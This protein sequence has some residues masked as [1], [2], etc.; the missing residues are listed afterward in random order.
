[1]AL[2]HIREGAELLAHRIDGA[3]KLYLNGLQRYHDP[4]WC[5][6]PL[7]LY[8]KAMLILR[9]I[10][11]AILRRFFACRQRSS[12]S[13]LASFC[14]HPGRLLDLDSQTMRDQSSVSKRLVHGDMQFQTEVTNSLWT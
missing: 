10:L 3:K 4:K 12:L 1:M 11:A 13:V 7:D 2:S 6:R 9:I 8:L 5:K 14:L